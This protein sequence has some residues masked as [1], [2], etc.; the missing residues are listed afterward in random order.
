MWHINLIET[1]NALGGVAIVPNLLGCADLQTCIYS[2]LDKVGWIAGVIL[3][4]VIAWSGIKMIWSGGKPEEFK[5]ASIAMWYASIGFICVL[6]ASSIVP[7]IKDL[8]AGPT[9]P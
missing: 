7:I 9:G 1:A 5:K 2:M 4:F 3:A 6:L 8:F